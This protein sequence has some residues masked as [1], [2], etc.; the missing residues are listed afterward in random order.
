MLQAFSELGRHVVIHSVLIG[1][2]GA[3]ET[4]GG[5]VSAVESLAADSYVAWLNSHLGPVR[6]DGK[7]FEE[8]KAF[9]R[10]KDKLIGTVRIKQRA[11]TNQILHL[12][13]VGEMM[14]RHLTYKEA[15]ATPEIWLWDR[16]R[17]AEAR[18]EVNG[19]L[20]AIFGSEEPLIAPVGET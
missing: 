14:R 18:R 19:Q 16:Q 8:T 5:L 1:G 7:P 20:R 9:G 11:G 17:L 2:A 15:F 13:A 12:K 3:R 4:L 6:F 10:I